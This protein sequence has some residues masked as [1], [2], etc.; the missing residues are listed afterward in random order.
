[1]YNA[2]CAVVQ[3]SHEDFIFHEDGKLLFW[4]LARETC[5]VARAK[6]F[7]MD[8]DEYWAKHSGGSGHPVDKS[9]RHFTSAVLDVYSRRKTEVDFINGA[10]CREGRRLG[11]PTPYNEAIWRLTR[12]LQDSYDIQYS[13][14]V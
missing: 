4:E 7:N 5:E 8:T 11:I 9:E 1:M 10:V 12:V 2:P 3:L 13:P 14:R 6:G